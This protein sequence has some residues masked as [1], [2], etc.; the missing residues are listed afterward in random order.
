MTVLID[1]EVFECCVNAFVHT[2]VHVDVT[3]SRETHMDEIKSP[4]QVVLNL[5][6][7]GR[8]F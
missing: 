4:V 7:L 2:V 8:N 1:W 3:F 6:G 5:R